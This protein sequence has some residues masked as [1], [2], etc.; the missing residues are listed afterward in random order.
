[1][2]HDVPAAIR[3]LLRQFDDA[4]GHSFESLKSALE[5]V[6]EADAFR[7]PSAYA[8]EERADGW[9]P[10]GSI[11]W[12]VAHVVDCKRY[13]AD[14]LRAIGSGEPFVDRP[15]TPCT[16]FDELRRSLDA[17]HA[18]Q[19]EAL[20][21]FAD[22]DLDRSAGEG[23][24]AGEFAAMTIRHDTWHASQIAVARRLLAHEGGDGA[25]ERD[26]GSPG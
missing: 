8:A 3:T 20:A 15:W 24:T 6:S 10:P 13:Y 16:G 17:A 25:G 12:Q 11:A 1:M 4:F 18:E 7:Q 9:P 22:D 2:M 26:A 21:A 14:R 23:M 19:R 5:G